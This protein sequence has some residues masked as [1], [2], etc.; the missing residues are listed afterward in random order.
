MADSS[1]RAGDDVDSRRFLERFALLLSDSGYP[2]M[3]ARV[4]AAL[5]VSGDGRRTAAELADLLDVGPSAISGAVKYLV[6]VG[7]VSREREPGQRVDHYRVHQAAWFKAATSSDEVY[8]RFQDTAHDGVAT[9]GAD[10][11][12]GA[13]FGETE[14]FFAFLREEVPK[15]MA[16]WRELNDQ[17]PTRGHGG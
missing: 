4:F 16:K 7:M 8:R 11:P 10:T 17:A 14:R 12:V 13:R 1:D 5:F 15:L 3:A 6:R 2:R 9:Y